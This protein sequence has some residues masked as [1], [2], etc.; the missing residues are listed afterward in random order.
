MNEWIGAGRGLRRFGPSATVRMG[1]EWPAGGLFV[2]GSGSEA[3]VSFFSKE[4][5][6]LWALELAVLCQIGS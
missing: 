4:F 3:S 6:A 1:R 2:E 5:N